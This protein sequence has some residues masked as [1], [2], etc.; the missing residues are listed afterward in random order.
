MRSPLFFKII[1]RNRKCLE[2]RK[3]RKNRKKSKKRKKR[4]GSVDA[5][6]VKVKEEP[7]KDDRIYGATELLLR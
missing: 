1:F 5:I 6:K 2:L 3:K 4:K 7:T